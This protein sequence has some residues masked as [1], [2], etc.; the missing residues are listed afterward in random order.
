MAN[1]L[2]GVR[3]GEPIG[4][5]QA[6]RFITRLDALKIAFNQAKDRQRILQE[7]PKV[8]NAWFKL[9][10][11]TKAKYGV[12]NNNIYNFNETRFQIGVIRLIKV[13]TSSKRYI[14]PTLT[15]L[16]DYKQIIVIQSIYAVG[17]IT[18]LFIIYKGRVYISTQY[19]ETLIPRN[20]KL[21]VSKN[22]QINNTLSL[23]Q[24][25]HFN[26]YIK[27][28]QV[29]VYRL[30]ILDRY[31]SHL[32]QEFKDYCLEN[33]ILTLYIPPYLLY[34]LQPLN[35][36]YFSLLKLKYSQRVRDLAR[37]RIFYINK[38]GLLPA[39]RDAFFNV[40]IIENY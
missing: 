15:Q 11:E 9:V 31:K 23:K 16:G 26:A 12:H 21:L 6:K 35:I 34:I 14:R 7:D 10:E 36:V 13:V 25:K 39:F 30:L 37:K 5:H 27:A 17:Y 38:E 24:L 2:L 32:N 20:Q 28:R 1:K 4:K 19:K 29:G 22:S 8:I 18:L 40:F 3:S 33:K